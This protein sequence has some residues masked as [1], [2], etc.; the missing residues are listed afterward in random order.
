MKRLNVTQP[1]N[2]NPTVDL[3]HRGSKRTARS[4]LVVLGAGM[5]LLVGCG[6]DSNPS[7][8]DRASELVQLGWNQF[9]QEDYV[10][11]LASFDEALDLLSDFPDAHAGRAWCLAFLDDFHE[12]RRA[13]VGAK[14][15][16]NNDAD[17]W[18]GGAFVFGALN[19]YDQVVLW[20]ENAL[21]LDNAWLF[22]YRTSITHRH[23]RYVMATAYWY[24]GSYEQC[25]LQLNVLEPGVVHDIDP[26]SL[27]ADL[28]RLFISPFS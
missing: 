16:D 5:L 4:I 10:S 24:R 18:A 17:T 25:R 6:G 28:Q 15:R 13:F 3:L 26:Q 19:D 23:L 11:A 1:D 22:T 7:R 21:A 20:A 27:L 14:E 9:A 2:G 8:S 12:A